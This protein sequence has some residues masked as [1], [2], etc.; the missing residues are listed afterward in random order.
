MAWWDEDD[1]R[2]L[3]VREATVGSVAELLER[4]K[5]REE[6]RTAVSQAINRANST[7]QKWN[8]NFGQTGGGMQPV[9]RKKDRG[10]GF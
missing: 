6:G 10:V 9:H 2:V 1:S 8:Q 5:Q 4:Q 7:F 3:S